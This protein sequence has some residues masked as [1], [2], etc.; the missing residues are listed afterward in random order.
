VSEST[1]ILRDAGSELLIEDGGSELSL[2]GDSELLE[3]DM[4]T[5]GPQ[6]PPGADGADASSYTHTQASA[7]STWTIAHNL[8]WRPTI[9]VLTT[10]GL[11]VIAEIVHLSTNT[12]QVLFV[13]PMA[14]SARCT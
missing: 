8:G 11:Q 3:L 6:G 9:T 4:G 2:V 14:G 10:G 5:T 7:S 1:L 12:A 13:E